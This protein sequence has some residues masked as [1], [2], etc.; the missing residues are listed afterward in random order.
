MSGFRAHICLEATQIEDSL[1]KVNSN[2]DENL[3]LQRTMSDVDLDLIDFTRSWMGSLELA[4]FQ[5][6]N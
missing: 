3:I 6:Y 2:T 5:L 1:T 4:D